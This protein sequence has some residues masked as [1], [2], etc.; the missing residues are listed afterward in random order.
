MNDVV[1]KGYRPELDKTISKCYQNLIKSCW[2]S[3]PEKRPSFS[4]IVNLFKT[5]REF[6]TEKIDKSEYLQY[7]NMIDPQEE[8]KSDS[9]GETETESIQTIGKSKEQSNNIDNLYSKIIFPNLYNFKVISKIGEG[10][11]SKIY[12]A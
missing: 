1:N 2:S 3:N 4:D 9:D 10:S 7:I 12:R 11:F 5:D 6:I 8:E